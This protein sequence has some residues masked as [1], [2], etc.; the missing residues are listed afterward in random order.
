MRLVHQKYKTNAF[1]EKTSEGKGYKPEPQPQR[2]MPYGAQGGG[3]HRLLL[4][5][6]AGR[7]RG[8][9]VA[10][11]LQHGLDVLLVHRAAQAARTVWRRERRGRGVS[12]WLGQGGRE[13]SV[14]APQ[15]TRKIKAHHATTSKVHNQHTL[16]LSNC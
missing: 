8:G 1:R 13:E 16:Q 11:L 4:G 5:H 7:Q 12:G 15:D 3:A 9:R 10:P 14:C 6:V 2:C